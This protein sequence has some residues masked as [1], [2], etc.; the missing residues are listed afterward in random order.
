VLVLGSR[1]SG[2][3]VSQNSGVGPAVA[4]FYTDFAPRVKAAGTTIEL[5]ANGEAGERGI[6]SNR[7]R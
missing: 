4:A 5:W 2:E 3:D 1:G 6:S 7:I